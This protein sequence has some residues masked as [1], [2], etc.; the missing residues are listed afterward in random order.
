MGKEADRQL[1]MA[2]PKSLQKMNKTIGAPSH[3]STRRA[4]ALYSAALRYSASRL[5]LWA[6][7]RVRQG[8]SPV[9]SRSIETISKTQSNGLKHDVSVRCTLQR[10]RHT[11][12]VRPRPSCRCSERPRAQLANWGS[13]SSSTNIKIFSTSAFTAG[14][15]LLAA[16]ALCVG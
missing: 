9:R 7:Y 10:P 3:D 16:A 5:V 14:S 11:E 13:K 8:T 6:H 12:P 2:Q 15:S 1:S 4:L